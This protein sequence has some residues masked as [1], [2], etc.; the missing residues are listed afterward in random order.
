MLTPQHFETALNILQT[1]VV[2]LDTKYRIIW[3]NDA[4]EDVT[5][6][7]KSAMLYCDLFSA[8]P[9]G[10]EQHDHVMKTSF[11]R[12]IT[13]GKTDRIPIARYDIPKSE[14]LS[15]GDSGTRYWSII[16]SP[17]F[18]SQGKVTLLLNQPTDITEMVMLQKKVFSDAEPT[19]SDKAFDTEKSYLQDIY[20]ERSY[21]NSLVQ[22]APG[23]ICVLSG[24]EH[25]CT[26]TNN[27]YINLIGKRKVKGKSV[28]EALPE[29]VAQGFVGLLDQVYQSG[30]PYIG[31]A[32]PLQLRRGEQLQLETCYVD[33]IYQPMKNSAGQVQG[34]FIQGHDVTEAEKLAQEVA[35]QAHH[36]PLTSLPNRRAVQDISSQL[37]GTDGPHVLLYMDLDHFK[38][39][40][41]RCG[42]V[43]GDEML[44]KVAEALNKES[45]RGLLA[46]VGGDEFVMVLEQHNMKQ[47]FATADH[48]IDHIENI[49]FYWQGERHSISMSIGMAAFGSTVSTS[50]TEAMSLAD[51]ACF[52]AKEKGRGRIQISSPDDS[53]VTAQ[54]DD[55]DWVTCL[56]NAIREDRIML[57]G[58]DIVS[59][60]GRAEADGVQRKE[61]LSRLLSEQGEIIPPSA[62]VS[63]AERFGVIEFLDKHII[64]KAF[65]YLNA[66]KQRMKLF[67]NISGITLSRSSFPSFIANLQPQFE[68]LDPSMVCF[69]ITETAAVNNVEET[70]RRMHELKKFGFEFALD[71]FGSGM[72]NFSYLEKL[73]VS[74]VKI[75][76]EFITR[77]Q[78]CPVNQIIVESI[79][80][81]AS[82]MHIQTIAECIESESLKA[83][84]Y[85]MGIHLG[86][87]YVI[88]KPTPLN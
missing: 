87:G 85:R 76:G 21:C 26:M 9:S 64:R 1:P 5:S 51:S 48:L 62:F 34:I 68:N 66:S 47:A 8:I 6:T 7:A 84:L 13:T 17:I 70:A 10:N 27:A 32:T 55:M 58:Q 22:Q 88:Q 24:P 40:N 18:D 31:R 46:R 28:Q 14:R 79:Q 12:I 78:D 81:V 73:P 36:D 63:A 86:Q 15:P 80:K 59:L 30:E 82:L 74:Y 29:L 67:V 77:M 11:K 43:A 41:D 4:Y 60:S 35:F 23:F 25:I 71:D 61:V 83:D 69:E 19:R 75:D 42:H 65:A 3:C 16:T 53:E 50:F 2:I 33:F 45:H 37:A 38:I 72:A 56:K 39:I 44:I 57:Y 52:L 49:I 54:L 20:N